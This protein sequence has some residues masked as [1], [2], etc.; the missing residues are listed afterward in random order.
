[1]ATSKKQLPFLVIN[2]TVLLVLLSSDW[3]LSLMGFE[4][5][6]W[7]D[8]FD[9]V[10]LIIKIITICLLCFIGIKF[11]SWLYSASQQKKNSDPL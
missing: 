8:P 9:M 10:K 3:V 7:A 2:M 11:F 1:M 6:V 5:N 4:Y